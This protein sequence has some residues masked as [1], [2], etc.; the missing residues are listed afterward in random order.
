MHTSVMLNVY[1]LFLLKLNV[2]DDFCFELPK[3][4]LHIGDIKSYA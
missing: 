2:S 3:P 4:K 1:I